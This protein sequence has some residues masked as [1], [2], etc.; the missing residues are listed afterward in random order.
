MSDK[1]TSNIEVFNREW[2]R[3]HPGRRPM[4]WMLRK[5][6]DLP[7]VRFHALPKSKRYPQDDAELDIILSR[8]NEIADHLLGPETPCWMI[9]TGGDD[10]GRTGEYA[11]SFT[12]DDDDP[13]PMVWQ[14]FIKP[15]DWR[16]EAFDEVLT[17]VANDE[18]PG[19]VIWMARDSGVIFAPYDGGFD[20]FPNNF[21]Q[22]DALKAK[23]PDWL[24][25]FPGGL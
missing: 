5:H 18:W 3:F 20:L 21:N 22:I 11:G 2:D 17:A 23:W 9:E 14:Y 13:Y 15:V 24:S 12:V 19:H 16:A 25:P 4:G 7:W 6:D 10:A 1:T 8:A